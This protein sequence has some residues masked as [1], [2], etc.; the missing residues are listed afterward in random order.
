MT[1]HTQGVLFFTLLARIFNPM[2]VM[3]RRRESTTPA[4]RGHSSTG[5]EWGSRLSILYSNPPPNKPHRTPVEQIKQSPKQEKALK[6]N[7]KSHKAK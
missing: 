2:G 5:G 4:L 7:A 1:G 3:G 6:R